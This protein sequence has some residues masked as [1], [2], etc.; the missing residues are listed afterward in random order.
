MKIITGIRRCGKSF[1]LNTLYRQA[2]IGEGVTED[3]FV[4]IALDRK[5]DM[6]FRNPNV[7]Y[8]YIKSLT[9]DQTRKYYVMID[10]IQLSYRVRNKDVDESMVAE[11][12]RDLLYTT[13]YDVLNDL[14]S[15]RNLDIYVTGSKTLWSNTSPTEECPWPFWRRT[16]RRSRDISGACSRA[17]T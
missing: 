3:S 14:M 12:D 17:C 9:R 11:D 5:S 2:L 1:L 6:K 7:L 8:D 16:R 4:E 10:E 15:C 13:F